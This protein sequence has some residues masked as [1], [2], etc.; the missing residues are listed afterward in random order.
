MLLQDSKVGKRRL[1]W[2]SWQASGIRVLWWSCVVAV[3]RSATATELGQH[4]AV[5]LSVVS[6]LIMPILVRC[7][8]SWHTCQSSQKT[9]RGSGQHL[10]EGCDVCEAVVAPVVFVRQYISHA[11]FIVVAIKPIMILPM[12]AV[13]E[14]GCHDGRIKLR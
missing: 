10:L 1:M 3:L 12:R 11:H 5:S 4:R 14:G 8:T 13:V 9:A 7:S 2:T 6:R